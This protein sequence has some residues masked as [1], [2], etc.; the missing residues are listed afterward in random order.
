MPGTQTLLI[1]DLHLGRGWAQRRRGELWPLTSDSEITKLDAVIAELAPRAIVFLGDL[2][3][4]PRPA[5]A[6]RDETETQL[7]RWQSCA[8]LTV[9]RG[10]HDRA[11]GFDYAARLG[12]AFTEE[13]C[14]GDC[15]AI[16]GDRPPSKLPVPGARIVLGHL[17]PALRIEDSAGVG[18]KLPAFLI[19]ERVIVLP[20]FSP[21][22]AGVSMWDNIPP[23]LAELNGSSQF[24]AILTTGKRVFRIGTLAKLATTAF[25]RG[26]SA[27][28]FQRRRFNR[29]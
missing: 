28:F 29:R 24:E 14:A 19:G 23:E 12:I 7:R 25:A 3:H 27:E 6:E 4:A 8:E 18:H 17:H 15:V 11:F 21:L 10:N 5:P 1:A 20:A 13:W 9:V 16:H 26:A 22:A 2:V